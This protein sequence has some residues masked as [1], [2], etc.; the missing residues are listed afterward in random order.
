MANRIIAVRMTEEDARAMEKAWYEYNASV[1]IIARLMNNESV[2]FDILQE[3]INI[4]E[5]RFTQCEMMK[6][7]LAKKYK[8]EEVD[9]SKF[10]YSFDFDENKIT[11]EEA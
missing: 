8:T 1:D 4:A 2:K 11:F 5:L 7:A 6:T 3:Y 10:N 9:L